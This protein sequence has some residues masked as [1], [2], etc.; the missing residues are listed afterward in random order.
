MLR[1]G[2]HVKDTVP[3]YGMPTGEPSQIGDGNRRQN[4]DN[5]IPG[6]GS[7]SSSDFLA[8][9]IRR[10]LGIVLREMLT[11]RQNPPKESTGQDYLW[12]LLRNPP[13]N[14]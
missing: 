14:V 2:Y 8:K 11:P 4:S 13:S 7:E 9:V 1:L 5:F 3:D 10:E 12:A 6:S